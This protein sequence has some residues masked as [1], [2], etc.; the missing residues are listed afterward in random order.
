MQDE[1][2]VSPMEE[3]PPINSQDVGTAIII[4]NA[5]QDEVL[6]EQMDDPDNLKIEIKQEVED[7]E[8]QAAGEEAEDENQ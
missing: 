8:E 3:M 1:L 7:F 4:Q 2:E 5:N 6:D